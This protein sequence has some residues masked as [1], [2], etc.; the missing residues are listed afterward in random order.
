MR[1]EIKMFLLKFKHDEKFWFLYRHNSFV[2]GIT[3]EDAHNESILNMAKGLSVGG[4]DIVEMNYDELE[5]A[6]G[7]VP[8]KIIDFVGGFIPFEGVEIKSWN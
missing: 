1:Q 3:E 4:F 8:Y 7:G 2:G 6:I 5:K